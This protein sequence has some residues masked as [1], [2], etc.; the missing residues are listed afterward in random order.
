MRDGAAD[1][2]STPAPD[3]D[4]LVSLIAARADDTGAWGLTVEEAAAA[5]DVEPV[6]FWRAVH[7]ARDRICFSDAIDG[8]SQDAVGDLVT[9]LEALG[10]DGAEERMRRA[11]LFIPHEPAVELQ[12]EL[13]F[14]AQ[15]FS[16][17]HQVRTE[18]L[19]AMIRHAGSVR[20]AADIYLGE[21][22]DADALIE[23]CAESFRLLEGMPLVGQA[24][25]ARCLR[26]L[27]ARHVL[28]RDSLFAGLRE[29]LRLEAARMGFTDPEER[30]QA[31]GAGRAGAAPA[32]TDARLQWARRVMGCGESTGMDDLRARYRALMM[33]HHPDADPQGLERCKD[34]NVAYSLLMTG[35]KEAPP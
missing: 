34:V 31:H 3:L 8:W 12:E 35:L 13:A 33:R 30:G 5:L 32:R 14:R 7:A 28:D 10:A 21:Y 11:G 27:M 6:R 18:E 4:A 17:G 26:A 16:A 22:A 23:G 15:R 19:E 20:A 2:T 25:A 24:T 9:V 29:R 1:P